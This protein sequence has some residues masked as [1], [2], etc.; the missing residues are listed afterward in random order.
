MQPWEVS[1]TDH[2]MING[3][4]ITQIYGILCQKDQSS[5][6]LRVNKEDKK[7]WKNVKRKTVLMRWMNNLCAV[8]EQRITSFATMKY[9]TNQCYFNKQLLQS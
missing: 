7:R 8:L 4:Y 5:P 3:S 6:E 9:K 1:D 2:E